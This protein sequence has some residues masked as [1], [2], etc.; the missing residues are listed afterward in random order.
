[1]EFDT[2][3]IEASVEATH[4]W[5]VGRRRLF[6]RELTRIGLNVNSKVLDVGTGTGA[7]L[8]L[9]RDYR[10][11]EVA[12]LESSEIAIRHCQSKGLGQVVRGD[13]CA[14]P[15]SNGSFDIVLATDIIEHVADDCIALRE[16][17]RV[18]KDGGKALIAVPAFPSLWGLQDIVAHHKRRYRMGPLREQMH[19][20]GLEP[21]RSYYFN[22]L[23]FG[24]IWL[25]RKLIRWSGVK[26]SSE[27]EFNTPLLNRFLSAVFALDVSTAPFLHPPFGVSI[28]VIA[29]KADK[30]AAMIAGQQATGIGIESGSPERFAYQ[31]SFYPELGPLGFGSIEYFRLIRHSSYLHLR[32]I[33]LDQMLPRI[34]HYWPRATVERMMQDQGLVDVRLIWVNEMSW[35]AIGTKPRPISGSQS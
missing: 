12:G 22:Y 21:R 24:P 23:L 11:R 30:A 34:A 3:A 9:L 6:A 25:A 32:L 31:W 35:S 15:F 19:K 27:N 29:E 8:R 28:L 4:W 1:M 2:Y 33:V 16:I 14:M 18:L 10:V 5:F 17:Y 7:N 13:V 26:R 20:V